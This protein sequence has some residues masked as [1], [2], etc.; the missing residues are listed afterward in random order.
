MR[1]IFLRLKCFVEE[2]L[3]I[4]K[5][6]YMDPIFRKGKLACFQHIIIF[7]SD[8]GEFFLS[9]LPDNQKVFKHT[10]HTRSKAKLLWFL[11][12]VP[13]SICDFLR[14]LV[15]ACVQACVFLCVVSQFLVQK[16]TTYRNWRHFK[17]NQL[18]KLLINN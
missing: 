12:S 9:A 1:W 8:F 7:G 4:F 14:T 10:I 17:N 11:G 5:S 13:A 16:L 15:R 2:D 3:L 18:I 6:Y